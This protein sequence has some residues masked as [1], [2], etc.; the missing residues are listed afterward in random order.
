MEASQ[1]AKVFMN[2]RSQAVRIPAEY[3]F[4]EDE[5]FVN[6]IGDTLMLTPKSSLS[7]TLKRGASMISE[8]FM[9]DGRPEEIPAVREEL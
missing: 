4:E 3:R 5:V 8:D 7:S 1:T 2:G 6:K 9:A